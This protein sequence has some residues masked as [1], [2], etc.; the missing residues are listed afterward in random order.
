MRPVTRLLMSAAVFVIIESLID[1]LQLEPA[2]PKSRLARFFWPNEA[3]R[4]P[5]L[6]G[7]ALI[8]SPLL[9]YYALKERLEGG[10]R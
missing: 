8:L 6:L 3:N 2:R 9:V 1:S 7:G 4:V 5:I 10:S